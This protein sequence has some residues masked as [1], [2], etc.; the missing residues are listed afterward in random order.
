MARA[1][2]P[3]VPGDDD[4]PWAIVIGRLHHTFIDDL[5]TSQLDLRAVQTEDRGHRPNTHGNGLLHEATALMHHS[6]GI[7]KRH[8]TR[9]HKS[10]VFTQA[11]PGQ[12]HWCDTAGP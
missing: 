7:G 2:G 9:R 1:H 3:S 6:D 8:G 11:V 4:L 12:R 10:C 5:H